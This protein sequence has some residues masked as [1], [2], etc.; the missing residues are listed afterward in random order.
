M[1]IG[2]ARSRTGD[3]FGEVVGL[4]LSNSEGLGVAPKIERITASGVGLTNRDDGL[5]DSY[6]IRGL[7]A[8]SGGES[9]RFD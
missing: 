3:A 5:W 8:S 6:L 4:E 9:E 7:Y 1:F 2:L